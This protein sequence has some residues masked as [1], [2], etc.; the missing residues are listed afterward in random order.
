MVLPL[1]DEHKPKCYL[2]HEGFE[3]LEDLRDH[4]KTKHKDFFESNKKQINRKPAP[5]DVTVF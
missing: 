5:G 2:C 1:V 4:Q 3:N